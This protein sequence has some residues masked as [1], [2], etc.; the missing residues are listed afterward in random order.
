MKKLVLV[1]ASGKIGAV[2]SKL[3]AIGIDAEVLATVGHIAENPRSLGV[4]G[5]DA[6][7]RETSYAFRADRMALL[8]KIQR[9][10]A[11]AGRI[12]MAMDDDQEGDVIAH[13][14]SWVLSDYKDKL[15]RVRLRALSE[16]E[17]QEAFSGP[18]G[19]DFQGPAANGICRRIVDRAIGATFSEV[20]ESNFVP[21]GRVQSSLLAS[22][23]E[24][25][26][27][28]G[29]MLIQLPGAKYE[30]QE[31]FAD[32]PVHTAEELA[33]FERLAGLVARGGAAIVGRREQSEPASLPW[34]F[35]EIVDEACSRLHVT[36]EVAAEALQEAYLRGK[37]SYPRAKSNGF[38]EDA[39]EVAARLA[40]HNRAAFDVNQI[41]R[42]KPDMLSAHESPRPMEDDIMLGRAFALADIPSALAVL[43]A[44]NMIECGQRQ[45]RCTVEAEVEG[46]KV[47][48]T[49][50]SAIG[51]RSWKA[52]PKRSG[53]MPFERDRAL[54][55]YVV[56]HDLGRPSTMVHHVTKFLQR[57]VLLDDGSSL[58]LNER[59]Q[60]W[61]DVARR[62]GFRSTTSRDM[63]HAFA[64]PIKDPYEAAKR[65]LSGAGM[66]PSVEVAIKSQ[67]MLSNATESE[68]SL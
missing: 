6:D 54:L 15:V 7:L 34:G 25:L 26:P 64:S 13:D 42:R 8:E 58:G 28:M 22:I 50:V 11:V 9:A 29:R 4:I 62:A 56:K 27:E 47:E 2:K 37:V 44:R 38:T 35:A 36:V 48:F 51:A 46:V 24:D 33:S 41:P 3:K 12:Y 57:G 60:K 53:Y 39:V 10:A 1:E 59:G 21:V 40:R 19:T 5:L 14:L 67:K 55:R 16:V 20:N 30:G 63:E 66:L 32:L 49:A 65:V 31:L 68:L 52:M 18:L 61:L 17:L 23:A 45:K 43:V